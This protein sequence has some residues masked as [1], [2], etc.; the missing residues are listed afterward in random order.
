[1]TEESIRKIAQEIHFEIKNTEDFEK[2]YNEFLALNIWLIIYTCDSVIENEEKRNTYL[3]LL[4]K[5][6]YERH[7]K[8]NKTWLQS[9]T[10]KYLEYAKAMETEHPS[11]PLWVLAT[12]VNKNLFG[13]IIEDPFLQ[14]Y[15]VNH[16]GLFIDHLGRTIKEFEIE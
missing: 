5:L 3:D 14:I 16:V 2:I 6:V 11:T 1:M 12:V 9:M 4:H 15:L 10:N 8:E 7:I 13:E